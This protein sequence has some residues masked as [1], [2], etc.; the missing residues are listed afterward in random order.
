MKDFTDEEINYIVKA[1]TDH[2]NIDTIINTLECDERDVRK[3]LSNKQLDRSRK[4]GYSDEL[5][6]RAIYLYEEKANAPKRFTI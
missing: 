6:D 1:Y 4:N 5:I 2:I 3:V